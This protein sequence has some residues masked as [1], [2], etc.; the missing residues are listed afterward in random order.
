MRIFLKLSCEEIKKLLKGEDKPKEGTPNEGNKG[1][2]PK[3]NE[4]S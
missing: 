1:E 4:N 3:E 2:T